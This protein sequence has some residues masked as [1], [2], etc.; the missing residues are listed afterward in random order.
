MA[1]RRGPLVFPRAWKHARSGLACFAGCVAVCSSGLCYSPS[2]GKS[3]VLCMV[4]GCI[5]PPLRHIR[6]LAGFPSTRLR[7]T[8]PSGVVVNDHVASYIGVTNE[9]A[10]ATAG[11]WQLVT[12]MLWIGTEAGITVAE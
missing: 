9:T 6:W 11:C 7:H 4:D 2:L 5:S 3:A 8:C 1:C 10:G 12:C